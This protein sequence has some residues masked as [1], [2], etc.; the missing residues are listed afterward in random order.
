MVQFHGFTQEVEKQKHIFLSLETHSSLC[1]KCRE[2]KTEKKT[3][4]QLQ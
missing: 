1:K 3:K 4:N 2:K